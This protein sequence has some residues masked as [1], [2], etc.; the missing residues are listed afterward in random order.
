MPNVQPQPSRGGIC[1]ESS[2]SWS[3][4]APPRTT[5]AQRQTLWR[6]PLALPAAAERPPARSGRAG[7]GLPLTHDIICYNDFT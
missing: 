4:V 7:T 1:P 6:P 3:E 2:L 5:H